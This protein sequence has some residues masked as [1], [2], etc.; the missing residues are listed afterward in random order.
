MDLMR[1]FRTNLFNAYD[2]L[3]TNLSQQWDFDAN[4]I[5]LVLY[6]LTSV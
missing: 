4:I 2:K 3:V 1:E 6:C 5:H